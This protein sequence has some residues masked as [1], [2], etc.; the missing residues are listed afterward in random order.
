MVAMGRDGLRAR[1]DVDA[2]GHFLL[3]LPVDETD[4]YQLQLQ[5]NTAP[6]SVPLLTAN[7]RVRVCA[8]AKTHDLGTI[9]VTPGCLPS[10]CEQERAG[11]QDC[12]TRTQPDCERSELVLSSCLEQVSNG[13]QNDNEPN[14]CEQRDCE[15][16]TLARDESCFGACEPMR[17][18]LAQ[19]ETGLN[20]PCLSPWVAFAESPIPLSFGCLSPDGQIRGL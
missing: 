5:A 9:W 11:L 8:S 18:L 3:A 1:T 19:C 10:T 16:A 14:V 13:C 12:M 17:Q 7:G 15:A 6:E 2:N 20:Q 4:S